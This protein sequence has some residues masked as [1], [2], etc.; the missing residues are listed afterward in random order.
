MGRGH[1]PPSPTLPFCWA[2]VGGGAGLRR[3]RRR[4]GRA[5]PG[6]GGTGPRSADGRAAEVTGP[7][8]G[9]GGGGSSSG[10]LHGR[11]RRQERRAWPAQRPALIEGHAAAAWRLTSVGGNLPGDYCYCELTAGQPGLRRAGMDRAATEPRPA[12]PGRRPG[13]WWGALRTFC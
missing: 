6:K 7:D 4:S 1:P 9:G 3:R 13:P 12:A 8:A 5:G 11:R 2:G 10:F